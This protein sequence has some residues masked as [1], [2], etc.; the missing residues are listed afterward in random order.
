MNKKILLFLLLF[1]GLVNAQDLVFGDQTFKA[2][3]VNGGEANFTAW[4]NGERI[5][6][7]DTNFDN[8]IQ[9]SEAAL[10]T[11][12]WVISDNASAVTSI[13]GIEGFTNL[14]EIYLNGVSVTAINL[15]AM[16]ALHNVLLQNL[17]LLTMATF[18]DLPALVG[19]S[20]M[21]G[22]QLNSVTLAN[23]P[24][25]TDLYL[26]NNT[27]LETLS[28]TNLPNLENLTAR[29]GRLESLNLTSCPLLQLCDV[30]N[31]ALTSVNVSG[32]V[33]L[34]SL[35]L[36][37]NTGLT[38]I[39]AAGCTLLDVDT[40]TFT[41]LVNLNSADF[42]NTSL[43]YFL[44][45]NGTLRTLNISGCGSL[46]QIDVR[47]N[48]LT[49]LNLTGCT[50][51]YSLNCSDNQINALNLS[52][53]PNLREMTIFNNVIASINTTGCH[54]LVTVNA[55]SNLIPALDLSGNTS[56]QSLDFNNNPTATLNLSGCT[57]LSI[58]NTQNVPLV[59]A[60]FSGC[61][62]LAQINITSSF[63]STLNIDGANAITG[64]L[65]SGTETQSAPITSL[66]VSGHTNLQQL[67]CF[68]TNLNTVNLEG[69]TGL[70]GLSL[71]SN[72]LTSIDFS[73]SPSI[74]TLN[75]SYTRLQ[76]IDVS[77]LFN[78]QGL[79]VS[80]NPFLEMIFAKNGINET[81]FFN[82]QNTALV[83]VCQDEANVE[84]TQNTLLAQGLPNVVVNS[85][86]SF[87]PGGNYNT[88]AG[89]ISF[90]I[91]NDGCDA[92]DA[93]QP[94]I[95]IDVNDGTVGSATF[96]N[97]NGGYTFYT[98][99]GN[100]ELMPG[101]ENES[102]F[103]I[104]PATTTVPF[105][106]NNDNVVTQNFCISAIGSQT[107][108]EIVI[109]PIWPA[110]PGFMAWYQIVIKNKGNQ[111][112]NGTFNVTYNQDILNYAM[113]TI[114]PDIQANGLMAWN[115]TNL[116]P[117]ENKS[118]YVGLNVN[119][120]T[121]TPPANIGDVLNFIA[122]VNPI[123]NDFTP[124]DNQFIFNQTVVGS[125]DP[126]DITCIQG[127]SVAPDT[128]GEYLH[129]VVNFEN[130]GTAEAEN[131]VVRVEIDQTKY[132]ISSLQL[133]NSSHASR[134][135]VRGNIAE[136]IFPGINLGA[137]GDPPVNGHG[138]VLFKIKTLHTLVSGDV[139]AKRA[140]IFFDYNAPINTNLASTTF[141]ILSNPQ[142]TIDQSI[143]VYP[144][145]AKN[146][147][148]ID[149]NSNIKSIELFDIQG[150]ILQTTIESGNAAKIDI[151]GKSGGIYFVR[152]TTDKGIKVSKIIKE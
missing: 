114:A 34:E 73:D 88:I 119:S 23:C 134:T 124:E 17:P 144:N 25:F 95:R 63:L 72:P 136:F 82:N 77:N 2:I 108:V 19:I 115:Y 139:A 30:T 105:L 141:G 35:F 32:L 100:F 26:E 4:S 58:A 76:S 143:T 112:A 103:I 3:L 129:Y 146:L 102:L 98:G 11:T 64:L 86:C 90:D 42:S 149:S 44:L 7:I 50:A 53:S 29:N 22:E 20:V 137:A 68:Y 60:N 27:N 12:L 15:V 142:F 125:F 79:S 104:S 80:G 18:A 94:N 62:A 78:L 123:L 152:V 97:A 16:P 9:A 120:P 45:P 40:G 118:Y 1:T 57:A 49:A 6:R 128:I 54:S 21:N 8:Q 38:T 74:N 138:N 67:L 36:H 66:D 69:C 127:E 87:T 151:S 61:A 117:F 39:N 110:K 46:G 71:Y 47:N 133:L 83:F 48:D 31:N 113:A 101:I 93:V 150:R 106:N 10:V 107:D 140:N 56:L 14:T 37:D 147:V 33:H 85:Y 13:E 121:Q 81:L 131:I 84:S 135:I 28:I 109:A 52:N 51:L 126:N 130:T 75:V 99:T 92:D 5:Y 111:T 122:T 148:S 24:V 132:D 116:L 96:T 59:S 41:D 65:I 145:P 55:S 91:D 43:Q 89:T 70:T